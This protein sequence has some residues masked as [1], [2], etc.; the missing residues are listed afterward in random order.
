ML[1]TLYKDE[2]THPLPIF[3]LL[4]KLFLDRLIKPN[5]VILSNRFLNALLYFS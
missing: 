5:E 2:R 4:Q 3:G 1:S